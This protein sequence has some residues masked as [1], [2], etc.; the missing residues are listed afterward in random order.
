MPAHEPVFRNVYVCPCGCEWVDFWSSAC[1][2]RCPDCDTSC[3]PAE[4]V[5]IEAIAAEVQEEEAAAKKLIEG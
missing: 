4:S 3:S 2:D 5:E 1:D